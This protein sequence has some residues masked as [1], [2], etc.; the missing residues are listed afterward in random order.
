MKR[1]A[2][3]GHPVSHS[4]SPAMQNAALADMGLGEDWHYEAIDVDE[5]GFR[6]RIATMPEEGFVG[7]NVTVPH[8]H[9]ALETATQASDSATAIGAANTLIFTP[10]GVVA[11]NTDAPGLID[12]L[13][14][15]VA[16]S[17]ALVFGAGGA[18]RAVLW[19]LLAEGAEVSVWNRNPDRA[20]DLVKALGGVAVTEPD[21]GE[22]DLFVNSSAAGLGGS[23]GLA[24]L[25]VSA[26]DFNTGQVVV[27]MVYGD[28]PSSLLEAASVAGA[29]TVDGL[30]IL[31]R[32]G[33]RS[34][35]IWTGLKPN[36]DVMRAAARGAS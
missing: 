7:A 13:P 35:E 4:R 16:G 5:D 21:A 36:L 10:A 20:E 18:A 14:E 17:K 26:G 3:I 30:E 32:Q 22:F 24:D 1:L 33:A 6:A 12:S 34:L 15:P 11:D 27:D 25:P 2:V 28:Q 19:A 9:A 23:D 29:K 8:K 31:V